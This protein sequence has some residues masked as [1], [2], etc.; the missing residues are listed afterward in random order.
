MYDSLKDK[1]ANMKTIEDVEKAILDYYVS[2]GHV[3][4]EGKWGFRIQQLSYYRSKGMVITF[5]TGN[6][7]DTAY[8]D[9][10]YTYQELY[11]DVISHFKI[12]GE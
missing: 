4:G 12:K 7:S 9:G 6:G 8:N 1:Q 3:I 5:Y 10:K 2:K 11:E